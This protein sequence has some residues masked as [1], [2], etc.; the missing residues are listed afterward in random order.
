M[1]SLMES[2]SHNQTGKV[3]TGIPGFDELIDGGLIPNRIY[4]IS[5]PA[6]S[7]KTIFSTQFLYNGII[8]SGENGVYVTLEVT[9]EQLRQDMLYLGWNL[10]KLE[11]KNKLIIIDSSGSRIGFDTHEDHT[12]PRPY[13]REILLNEVCN[14]IKTSNAKRVVIDCID[15]LDLDI[16]NSI[17]LRKYILKF[18][19]ILKSL[20]CTVFLIAESPAD[21][22]ISR[23]DIQGFTADGIITLKLVKDKR[24]RTETFIEEAFQ[25][26]NF[27]KEQSEIEVPTR[28]I[29][30]TKMRGTAH[31]LGENQFIISEN[32]IHIKNEQCTHPKI[33]KA[34]F[35][36]EP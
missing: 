23:D 2:L 12:V 18:T 7:G 10:K 34:T 11:K 4:L 30:I 15:A 19:T 25:E 9:P 21:N 17:E 33:K 35:Q 5:G 22:K 14:C 13:T 27:T 20:G 6:G 8:Q 1:A 28:K 24:I 29:E 31:F 16:A 36:V 26:K 32:G 3:K